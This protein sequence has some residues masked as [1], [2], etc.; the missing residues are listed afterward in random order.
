MTH[1]REHREI[2]HAIRV[3]KRRAEIDTFALSEGSDPRSLGCRSQDRRQQTPGRHSFDEFQTVRDIIRDSQIL[4][5]RLYRN[6]ERARY[7]DLT[8]ANTSRLLNQFE[9]AGKYGRLQDLLKQLVSKEPHPILRLSFVSLEEKIV[10]D[11]SAILIA[12]CEQ[13]NTEES[14]GALSETAHQ[15]RLVA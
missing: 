14:R 15:G 1:N 10:E 4:H 8:M 2:A 7:H 6:L 13:R 5:Q 12:D 11:F 3:S 9:R